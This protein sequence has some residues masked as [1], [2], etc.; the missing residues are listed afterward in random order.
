MDDTQILLSDTS[1][2]EEK[3]QAAINII[4][5]YE[6]CLKPEQILRAFQDVHKHIYGIKCIQNERLYGYTFMF[7]AL[8][9]TNINM[10]IAIILALNNKF[11]S[12]LLLLNTIYDIRSNLK[13]RCDHW[14]VDLYCR[15]LNYYEFDVSEF[16]FD[17]ELERK[18]QDY[19]TTKYGGKLTKPAMKTH[20][21]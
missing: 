16:Y 5:S 21:L 7:N 20:L 15:L 9:N 4:M 18:I 6:L 3:N 11:D 1:S 10:Y 17:K 19:R 14:T 8:L 13:I 12:Y 2:D